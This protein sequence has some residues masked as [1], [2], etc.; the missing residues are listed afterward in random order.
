[1][2]TLQQQLTDAMKEAMRTKDAKRLGTIRMALAAI[3][4]VAVDERITP[5]DTR[6]LAILDKQIKQRNDSITQFRSA[7]RDDLADNEVA[8]VEILQSFMPPPLDEVEI[9]AAIAQAIS[10]SGAAS[11]QDM[12]K[13]MALLKPRLQG[14]ADMSAV[15]ALIRKRLAG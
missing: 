1:M 15:S 5:D 14:R 11:M 13:V 2:S 6:V 10:D 8:E 12:G 9:N 4:Q 3:Q 7:G